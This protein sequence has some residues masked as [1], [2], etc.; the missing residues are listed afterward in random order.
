MEQNIAL[1]TVAIYKLS[2][3]VLPA[4]HVLLIIS[5]FLSA[6]VPLS[7]VSAHGKVEYDQP[8]HIAVVQNSEPQILEHTS[9]IS[10]LAILTADQS[11]YQYASAVLEAATIGNVDEGF[12]PPPPTA[13][14]EWSGTGS[15]IGVEDDTDARVMNSSHYDSPDDARA[16]IVVT[17]DQVIQTSAGLVQAFV[18]TPQNQLHNMGVQISVADEILG[19]SSDGWTISTL[20][21]EAASDDENPNTPPVPHI[22]VGSSY[23]GF[24]K[25]VRLEIWSNGGNGFNDE[26]EYYIDA[27]RV[28]GQIVPQEGLLDPSL[29]SNNLPK[30]GSGDARECA[31]SGCSNAQ[32][33]AGDPI[34]TRS[35]NFD[36]SLVDLSLQTIAGPLTLQR[37]YASLGID[38]NRYPTDLGPGWTHNHDTR[39]IFETG[40]VWFKGHTINQYKFTDNGDQTYSPYAGVLAN[41]SYNSETNTYSLKASDQS[42]YT[43]NTTGQLQN[44][45]NELGYGFEYSY[46]NNQLYRV[47]EA[48][49]GRYLQFIYQNNRLISV[50]DSS[51]PVRTVSFGYDGNGDLSSFTDVRGKNW[52][53]EYDGS[54]HHLKTL[55]DPS[56]PAKTFLSN[57]YD[58]QGRVDEQFNGKNER[59]IKITFNADGTS[60]LLDAMGRTA[61][62]V[63]DGL[64]TNSARVDSAGYTI[65][66]YYDTNFRPSLVKDQDNRTLQY[67]WSAD[68]ANLTSIKDAAGYE[69]HLQYNSQNHL[70]QVTDPR[71]QVMTYAYTGSL[72]TEVSRQTSTGNITTVYA[73]TTSSDSPQPV[74]LLKTITDALNHTTT[75]TYDTKGQLTVVKDADDKET[76][77]AYDDQGRVTDITNPLGQVTHT[78][79][80][81]AGNA[82]KVILNYDATKAQ[83]YQNQYNLTTEFAFDDLG[84]LTQTK[85][86]LGFTTSYAY[87]DAG[88]MVQ[89]TDSYGKTTTS[90]FNASGQV[91]SLTDPLGQSTGYEYDSAGRVWKVKDALNRVILTYAYKSDSTIHTETRPTAAGDYIITYNTYDA[92]KRPVAISDN[93]NHSSSVTYD[94][95]GSPLIRTDAMG[96][97]TKYEYNDLGLLSAVTQ[98]Y[99]ANPGSGDDPNATNARTE[100][101]YDTVGNLTKIKDANDHETSYNYD[102]LNRL[103]K[104]T[105]PLGKVIE[106]GYDALGNRTSL[107]DATNN[108]TSFGYDLASRLQT[109]DYPTAMSD[110]SFGYDALSRLTGMDDGLGHTTWVYDNLNRITSITDPFNKTVGYG[111]D[112]NSKRTSITYP[113]P[114]S[115]TITYQYNSLDQLTSVLDG[116][117]HLADYGYDIAGWLS[118]VTLANGVSSTP[119]YDLSGQLTSLTHKKGTT[120]YASYTYHYNVVGNRDQVQE[121]LYYPNFTYLP[122]I[123]NDGSGGQPL[124]MG[125]AP[126]SPNSLSDSSAYP[127]PGSDSL[128]QPNS[129]VDS[130]EP[131]NAYPAPELLPAPNDTSFF[132]NAWDFLVSLFSDHT[133]TVSAHS[134]AS[135]VA[136]TQNAVLSRAPASSQTINYGYD[137][138]NRLTSANYTSGLTYSFT[139]DKVGNRSSQTVGGVSTTYTYDNADRLTN[140]GGMPFTWDDNGNLINDGVSTYTYDFANRL[141]GVNGLWSSFTFGYDGLGNRYQQTVNAQTITYVLDQTAGLSQILYDGSS[142]YYYGLGRISQQKNGVSDYFLTDG[143]VSVR[144][145]ANQSGSVSFGQAFDPFGNLI[146]QSGQGGSNYGYSG[147]WTDA[148]GLQNLRAR[149]YS[150]SQGRFL[151]KDPFSGFMSQPSTLNAYA[152]ATNNPILM[153]DPSG[154]IAP[155]LVAAGLG[156]LI[157]AGIDVGAQLYNMQPTSFGQA[158][159]CLNWG[160]VGVSFGAGMVAGLTGF[161]VFGGMT[162]LMGTGFIANV[163]AGAI[164]G[165][166]AGQYGRL[167]GLVLSGQVSQAGGVL[168]RPQ[169]MV[170][171]AALGGAFAGIGYGIGRIGSPCSF[172]EDTP[173]ATQDGE[174]PISE[175]KV[176]DKVLA[177]DESTQSTGYYAVTDTFSHTDNDLVI[178]VIDGE[179]VET[180]PEHPFYTIDKGWIASGDLWIGAQI[181]RS[182]GLT[183]DI[184]KIAKIHSNKVMLNLAVDQAHTFFVGDGKWL[185]HNTCSPR[186]ALAASQAQERVGV[187]GTGNPT[188]A[189]IADGSITT[190]SG[191]SSR[192]GYVQGTR[193]AFELADEIGFKFS[194]HRFDPASSPGTYYASH[195]EVQLASLAPNQPIGVSNPMCTE[196]QRFFSRLAT[197]TGQIQYV[198]DPIQLWIFKP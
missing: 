138:L 120:Q 190:H 177:Y 14:V 89:V 133:T 140:V 20:Y 151:T 110:V 30:N 11:A 191:W 131:E 71:N 136:S 130:L 167:T 44:W 198:K 115:K 179:T 40:T 189:T 194:P 61:T 21:N 182:D 137:A 127:A 123:L 186:G 113:F 50:N 178:L 157:G 16:C 38:T 174:K 15:I 176:G 192:S 34:D 45:R 5:F 146:G 125:I 32:A 60:T 48:L 76:H 119:G 96:I 79:Y 49:S 150:P 85:N 163:A 55:K 124:S 122:A 97:V 126:L 22:W 165:I 37:S 172:S 68:G 17:F 94:A 57:H 129:S 184:E 42:V 13:K 171:D 26:R 134:D 187:S 19:C 78:I 64:N 160:E 107:T 106:Y 132:Q 196:C 92:L 59:V 142:S 145:L 158:I 166:V 161:T 170:I 193:Q 51:N 93:V 58:A 180:T 73:Y 112:D 148:S 62:D 149:Y 75:F 181:L 188:M 152:Y 7:S 118:G 99:K 82:T 86:T 121:S 81:P 31:V 83:N 103:W 185:V 33:S 116:S 9:N 3:K 91:I 173:V 95:Y 4:I 77:F 108:T 156:G 109:I 87:D 168:F 139:Y 84:R 98:N 27:V 104:I 23:T 47:T 155:L 144:Q 8:A 100:Y 114:V 105:N 53:Y 39:L 101:T 88:R 66:K 41:L 70:T 147:E 46:S 10:D 6:A 25:A 117:T 52:S 128:L 169:D 74:G 43:F 183:G 18:Y 56:T 141:T 35:G 143:S 67:Q 164:S 80:D 154:E 29:L 197:F 24:V 195:A 90:I 69:T 111:Y 1:V 54:S 63:Y 2:Q 65:Q 102:I 12:F 175:I 72:L 159:H 153:S 28:F 162:A 36:Y 135:S